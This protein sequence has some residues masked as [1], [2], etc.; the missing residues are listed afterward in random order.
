MQNKTLGKKTYDPQTWRYQ[1]KFKATLILFLSLIS[2]QLYAKKTWL[3]TLESGINIASD[4]VST[5]NSLDQM[6]KRKDA[7]KQRFVYENK[8]IYKEINT[9]DNE[10][11]ELKKRLSTT[12]RELAW[13]KAKDKKHIKA[14][15][16]YEEALKYDANSPKTWHGYGWSLSESGRYKEA[17]NAF[18]MSINL[19]GTSKS[20]RYLGWNF[21]RQNDH[22]KAIF[23]YSEALKRDP[24]NS[25]AKYAL[26]KSRDAI[27]NKKSEIRKS[28]G[29][30]IYSLTYNKNG[31]I[32]K[33]SE[34]E[35]IYIGK[36]CDSFSK[37]YGKGTWGW[38]NGG[39]KVIF[40]N[41]NVEFP[42]Q[43]INI[44]NISKCR[45]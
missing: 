21:A 11:I 29:G 34:G 24:N 4:V 36:D 41:R 37:K 7:T 22:E 3:N 40:K 31:A 45:F 26:K 44:P 13:E 27:N 17:E 2:T 5:L 32:L 38:A 12:K 14:I 20:W 33:P 1:L 35:K 15:S 23:C 43:E 8:V 39:F 6:A 19:G 16:L 28:G 42:K 9:P 10:K 18:M 25:K 30:V